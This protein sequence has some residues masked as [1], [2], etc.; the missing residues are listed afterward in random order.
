MAFRFAG[1]KPPCT[2][3]CGERTIGCAVTCERWKK[4]IAERNQ[5]YKKRYA[6]SELREKTASGKRAV[7][8]MPQLKKKDPGWH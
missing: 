5:F 4:Y 3:D 6:E 8:R 1:P 7:D 2:K